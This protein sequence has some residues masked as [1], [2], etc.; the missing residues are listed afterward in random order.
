MNKVM[1]RFLL[2]SIPLLMTGTRVF[3]KHCIPT[4][5]QEGDNENRTIP[6]GKRWE[7]HPQMT[8]YKLITDGNRE[9]KCKKSYVWDRYETKIIKT[10]YKCDQL[11]V[12]YYGMTST[13][14]SSNFGIW[15][16]KDKKQQTFIMQSTPFECQ[17]ITESDGTN[18]TGACTMTLSNE[19]VKIDLV[20][21]DRYML[22]DKP[23]PKI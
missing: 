16:L 6:F 23:R 2:I 8:S 7:E 21:E 5:I 3:A 1:R 19:F 13:Q 11:V 14:Y 12:E 20:I 4:T 9:I 18:K 10:V 15:T 17:C 22:V